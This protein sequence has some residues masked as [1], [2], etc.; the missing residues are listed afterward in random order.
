MSR[1]TRLLL[2]KSLRDARERRLAFGA[3]AVMLA[4][5][6]MLFVGFSAARINLEQSCERTYRQLRF[7]DFY[8]TLQS[9]PT[10]VV[11]RVRSLPGVE[12]AEGRRVIDLRIRLRNGQFARGHVVGLPHER[13]PAVNQVYLEAGR[14][15]RLRTGELLMERRFAEVHGYRLHDRVE[16]ERDGRVRRLVLV[17]LVSSPEFVWLAADRAD[18]RSAARRL[19]VLFVTGSD[20][21]D[22]AGEDG[23]NE[24]HVRV[25]DLAER[26]RIMQ[27]AAARLDGLLT[28]APVPREEQAS[29]ALLL[30]DRRAFAQVAALFPVVFAGLS[31]IVMVASLMQL[32][33]RQR[34]QV[35]VLL[36]QG[37][38]AGQLL[39]HYLVTGLTVGVPGG[40][41]GALGGWG[42]G[43]LCTRYYTR[44]LGIPL[45]ET[46]TPL[47][48]MALALAGSLGVTLLAGW[49]AVGRLVRLEP[50]QV[51]RADFAPLARGLRPDRWIPGLGRAP[52]LL[53]LPL[54]NLAR[55]PARTLA[56]ALGIG[57]GVGQLMLTLL[58]I[59]SQKDA[60]RLFFGQVHRYDFQVDLHLSSRSAL[61][62]IASWPGV[63]RVEGLLWWDVE[64]AHGSR[65][66]RVGVWG[67]PADSRLLRLLDREGRP[68]QPE[69][70]L[71]LGPLPLARLAARPGDRVSLRP[72]TSWREP[73]RDYPVGPE[74]FEPLALP[75]KVPLRDLQA[76]VARAEPVPADAV[77]MLLL[78]VDPSAQ[79]A[80]RRRLYDCPEVQTV[81]DVSETRADV[82]DLL[83]M[84]NAY[85]G[86]MLAC[87]ALLAAALLAGT[88]SLNVMDR[89]RELATLSSLGVS[90][91]KLTALLLVETAMG[92]ALGL[93]LG[94]PAGLALGNWFLAH[95]QPD[96]LHMTASLRV[97]TVAGAALGS[98]L[99]SL[100][101]AW[102]ALQGELARPLTGRGED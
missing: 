39:G 78:R 96:L 55:Q 87:S 58:L 3:C 20:A 99:L 72:A 90:D 36:S 70:A 11:E 102:M 76:Q 67:L 7:L 79:E 65:S 80:V 19:G 92:W 57:L 28:A 15:L 8:L 30:R 44:S 4:V 75:P 18:P 17:G 101:V 54:R 41:A 13:P 33:A 37:M 16:L 31:L 22:L 89:S 73:A 81:V 47:T 60:L 49:W 52:Y 86:L 83:R 51:L 25:R 69:H 38:S 68:L 93:G 43:E 23:I 50:V 97:E 61:P 24:L 48:L 53:R 1:L 63:R 98:L 40:L 14:S 85:L 91:G 71:L 82:E 42:L 5:A 35:G 2:L 94:L 26:D 34:R 45:V 46:E 9:A 77:N 12:A 6:G 74:L 32:I 56:V 64:L 88:T 21:A 62:P 95:I 100:A 27:A 59:D 84:L 66:W 29:H 10:E